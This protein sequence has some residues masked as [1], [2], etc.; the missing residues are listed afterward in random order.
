MVGL[1]VSFPGCNGDSSTGW[2]GCVDASGTGEISVGW[3]APGSGVAFPC[4]PGDEFPLGVVGFPGS[5]ASV[6]LVKPTSC[7]T[8][9]PCVDLTPGTV[10]LTVALGGS[11][12]SG[13][14]AFVGLVGLFGL[15]IIVPFVDFA[16]M[17]PPVVRRGGVVIGDCEAS[18]DSV[19][20]GNFVGL[21]TPAPAVEGAATV[22][23]V[24]A[25]FGGGAAGGVGFCPFKIAVVDLVVGCSACL[26]VVGVVFGITSGLFASMGVDGVV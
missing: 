12:G 4:F 23:G 25:T 11:T 14:G 15:G 20:S 24:V 3:V 17:P 26:M 7:V 16:G 21:V 2:V 6:G 19:R 10:G 9:F 1:A 13:L 18:L 8:G 5:V 22:E